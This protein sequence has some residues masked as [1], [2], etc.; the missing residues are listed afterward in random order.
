GL[1]IILG[2]IGNADNVAGAKA[3]APEDELTSNEKMSPITPGGGA[4][5]K[6]GGSLG[7][8]LITTDKS[9]A[10]A[11]SSTPPDVTQANTPP[12]KGATPSAGLTERSGS[13]LPHSSV[14]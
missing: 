6:S 14:S 8:S 7:S 13:I 9:S 1:P 5:V 4:L 11:R 10:A 3:A 12:E 2:N